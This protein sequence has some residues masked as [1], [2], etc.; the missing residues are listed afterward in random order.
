MKT[1]EYTDREQRW[2]DRRNASHLSMFADSDVPP[3][4]IAMDPDLA[5]AWAL[6][7]SVTTSE[8]AK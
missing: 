4:H 5:Y 7:L 1:Q 8:P 6:D 3:P 2:R